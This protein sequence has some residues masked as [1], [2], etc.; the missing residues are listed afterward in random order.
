MNLFSSSK[1][2]SSSITERRAALASTLEKVK[3]SR[4]DAEKKAEALRADAINNEAKA[5]RDA[6]ATFNETADRLE[7]ALAKE[8]T[9]KLPGILSRYRQ[10]PSEVTDALIEAW[11]QLDARCRDQLGEELA[12]S[13]LIF[14]VCETLGKPANAFDAN[15]RADGAYGAADQLARVMSAP[16]AASS[17]SFICDELIKKLFVACGSQSMRADPGRARAMKERATHR[18]QTIHAHDYDE[19]PMGGYEPIEP[20]RTMVT[21]GLRDEEIQRDAEGR[22][23]L[24]RPKHPQAPALFLEQS[25]DAEERALAGNL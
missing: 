16:D 24:Y 20:N 17:Q 14:A 13:H 11:S 18:A 21:V 8:V 22:K 3:R 23:V 5:T 10:A 19:V 12:S 2:D 1:L 25:L 9:S 6:H 4:A 7:R 15:D